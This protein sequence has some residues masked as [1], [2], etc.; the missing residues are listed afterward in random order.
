MPHTTSHEVSI[1]PYDN[2]AT[3]ILRVVPYDMLKIAAIN[4]DAQD[5]EDIVN[6]TEMDAH[7]CDNLTVYGL[8]KIDIEPLEKALQLS[9]SLIN[10]AKENGSFDAENPENKLLLELLELYYKDTSNATSTD[11]S[12]TPC[13]VE[14]EEFAIMLGEI[15][16]EQIDE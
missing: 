11:E 1:G 13:L 14:N 6:L 16:A 10:E 15:S 9:Y 12:N 2:L 5:D 4:Y 3:A 8:E 7:L